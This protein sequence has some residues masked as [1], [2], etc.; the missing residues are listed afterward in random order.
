MRRA[1][2]ARWFEQEAALGGSSA[3][4]AGGRASRGR[5]AGARGIDAD[6]GQ[7]SPTDLLD[8]P[9]RDRR[10]IAWAQRL[11]AR[12]EVAHLD[13]EAEARGIDEHGARGRGAD[14]EGD[15]AQLVER[16]GAGEAIVRGGGRRMEREE[17]RW[18]R[19]SGEVARRRST[20]WKTTIAGGEG[21]ESGEAEQAASRTMSGSQGF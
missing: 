16:V 21:G 3:E 20:R 10:G 7:V 18:A 8:L 6:E 11:V 13:D 15:Q 4:R 5:G 2:R 1:R 19:K 14:N 12:N 9:A 17:A